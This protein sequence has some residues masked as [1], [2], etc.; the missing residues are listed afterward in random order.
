[1]PNTSVVRKISRK[2]A[3]YAALPCFLHFHNATHN[4]LILLCVF[5]SRLVLLRFDVS[6]VIDFTRFCHG[7]PGNLRRNMEALNFSQPTRQHNGK[8]RGRGGVGDGP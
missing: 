4:L 1:M 7:F 2:E 8:A 6:V 3:S 5:F